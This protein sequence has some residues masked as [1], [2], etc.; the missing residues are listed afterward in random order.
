MRELQRMP[1]MDIADVA[2]DYFLANGKPDIRLSAKPG[3]T[4]RLRI[5]DG[6]ATT[7]FYLEF[8]DGPMTVISADGQ[9]VK[10]FE[11]KRFLI[12]VAETYDVLVT[13]PPSGA[14]ELRATAHDGSG[15]ASVWIGSGKQHPA[16]AIPK[17]NLYD[18]MHP[19]GARSLFSLTPAGTMG[20][21]DSMVEKGM[22]DQ[23]GMMHMHPMNHDKDHS[24]PGHSGRA[25]SDHTT[26]KGK[27]PAKT[28]K[29]V[30]TPMRKHSGHHEDA[31][32]PADRTKSSPTALSGNQ[33]RGPVA[34]RQYGSRFGFLQ[35][36]IAS[37][38]NLAKEGGD[39]RPWTPYD[40]LRAFTPTSFPKDKPVREIRLTLDGDMHRY[41]WFINNKPLS[42]TD[43][44]LIKAGEVVRF[45]MI[46]RTMMHHPMHLHGHFFRVVNVQGDHAPLKHTV[47]VAPMTTKVIEFH[48]DEMGDWFFH[49]HLLYHMK[50]GM[51]RLIH[52]QDF[53]PDPDVHAV[54]HKLYREPWYLW[55]EAEVLSN[56]TEG[57]LTV[58]NTRIALEASWEVG[59]QKVD[60]TEWEGIAT[61]GWHANRFSS[62]FAGLDVTGE[63]AE[64]GEA[65]GILG[66]SY[67]LPLNLKTSAW[68]DTDGGA[69]FMLRKDLELT[70][71]L[72]LHGE[73]EYD[74]HEDWEG[75]LSLD[76][77]LSRH[78][79]LK[80]KWHSDFGFGGGLE[81]RF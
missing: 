52:Y 77:M 1:P 7:Y 21:P 44:I 71:R 38:G 66:L 13:V 35:A 32:V 57:F 14:H 25:P 80:G 16:P 41:V 49:C 54:R 76:Y 5:I 73:V 43:H 11:K 68:L 9:D 40:D 53:T 28:A 70:P 33:H 74:T 19:M 69:R 45:I 6:S 56:M 59:W 55:G 30:E 31:A 29:K 78:V 24:T 15:Y 42:E 2:Y 62:F 65:R 36:D 61:A 4:V 12:S 23:P 17:P 47:D 81:I 22:F 79:S 63:D 39:L 67:L 48:A 50:S 64:K 20:M 37:R 60:N 75:A 58:A 27:H 72:G 46:N 18:S 51:A 10:P 3:E 8:A 34:A 26:H